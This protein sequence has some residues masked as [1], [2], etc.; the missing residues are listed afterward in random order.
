M[1][2]MPKLPGS[3]QTQ[4]QEKFK[5]H[6]LRLSVMEAHLKDFDTKFL[7]KDN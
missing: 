5:E 7:Q 2:V 3:D 1:K 4:I 6:E